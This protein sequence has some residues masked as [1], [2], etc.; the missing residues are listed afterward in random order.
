MSQRRHTKFS[1]VILKQ[2]SPIF[3]AQRKKCL[4]QVGRRLWSWKN[5]K[6]SKIYKITII[7]YY[8]DI[9]FWQSQ[10]NVISGLNEEVNRRS[11]SHEWWFDN[12]KRS[13]PLVCFIL[14]NNC[15]QWYVMPNIFITYRVWEIESGNH[16][17]GSMWFK[18]I[19]D[20]ASKKHGLQI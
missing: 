17:G 6:N 3:S 16:A 8:W 5:R 11:K 13:I 1:T 4:I 2:S 20:V 10:K 19:E 7:I 12:C 18:K 14:E 15:S 9:S